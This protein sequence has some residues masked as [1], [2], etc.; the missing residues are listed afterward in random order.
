MIVTTMEK[1]DARVLAY[2]QRLADELAC[3]LVPR[4]RETLAGLMRKRADAADGMLVVGRD[5]LRFVSDD[6]PPLFYHPSMA[7]VRAKRLLDGGADALVAATGAAPGDAVLDCTAGLA[8][9]ALVLAYAVGAE[10]RITAVEASR[11]L[12]LIVREGLRHYRTEV[13]AVDEAMRRIRMVRGDHLSVL[14]GMPDRSV[15]IVTFDPM[16]SQPV[17]TSASIRPLRAIAQDEPLTAEA[18]TEARRVARKRIVL[19]EHRDSELFERF[20]FDR[21]RSSYSAVDYGVILINDVKS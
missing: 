15:D 12:H 20:G 14:R 19:K 10:G 8:S 17:L 2:A 1:P 13:D 5:A 21:V 18:V 3:P 6:G 16:F 11:V 7:L 9:D 4:K